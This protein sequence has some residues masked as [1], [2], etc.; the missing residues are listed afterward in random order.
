M[1][2]EHADHVRGAPV[3]SK[4]L[5]IPVYLNRATY[6]GLEALRSI[7]NVRF[8]ESARPFEIGDIETTA[9][10]VPHDAADPVGFRFTDGGIAVGIATDLGSLTP[11][12]TTSLS[13][14]GAVVIE[15]NHDLEMLLKG[16]YPDYL[17]R[18][19]NGPLGHL[20]NRDA[21]FLLRSIHHPGLEKVVLAHLSRANNRPGLTLD[22]ARDALGP[23]GA[24]IEC[25]LGWH[26]RAGSIIRV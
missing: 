3:I 10:R 7:E 9:F 8:F 26:D 20:S 23:G 11:E 16:N 19:I 4:R 17:K 6:L 25:S 21:G 13:E 1:T 22:S 18:W 12:V 15:S 2:H 5:R 24:S 14:C